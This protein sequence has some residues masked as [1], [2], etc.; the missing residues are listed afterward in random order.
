MHFD[1]L[2]AEPF[3]K[4]RELTVAVLNGEALCG[5]RAEA[6]AASTIM[7]PNIPTG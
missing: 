4:G 1:R 2:L 5:D 7:T 3:V 6:G